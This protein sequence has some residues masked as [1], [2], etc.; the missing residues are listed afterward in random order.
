MFA[1]SMA[2]IDA[3]LDFGGSIAKVNLF[4]DGVTYTGTMQ[5]SPTSSLDFGSNASV[6]GSI[7]CNGGDFSAGPGFSI[8]GGTIMGCL[9]WP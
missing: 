9:S 6:E 5:L 8:S 2:R 1:E 7:N 4:G 3:D